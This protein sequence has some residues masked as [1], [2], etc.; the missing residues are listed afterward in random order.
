[1]TT[2]Q[3]NGNGKRSQLSVDPRPKTTGYVSLASQYQ[4]RPRDLPQLSFDMIRSM[5]LDPAVRLGLAMRTAPICGI[6][7]AYKGESG[8]DG[9]PKWIPGVLAKRP[10]VAE[11][12]RRQ[13]ARIWT[14][15]LDDILTAQVWGWSAGEVMN[16]LTSRGTVEVDYLL[17]RHS[18]D[19]RALVRGGEPVGCRVLRV[20]TVPGGHVDLEFPKCW[21]H[22]HHPEAGAFY[23]QSILL[24]AYS[25]WADKAFQGGATDIRRLF[26]H[27]DAYGGKDMTYPDGVTIINGVEV[28]NRDIA[29]QIAEQLQSGGVTA[30]PSST[31]QH[32]NELWKL[33][34]ATVP[35]NPS[36]ILQFP[37]D[38]DTEIYHG[39]EI[40]DD[41]IESETGA[42]A[43]KRVPMAAFYN[44]LDL[45][46]M[47]L[48]GDL[49][50]QILEPLVLINFG[51]AEEFAV[52]HKPLGLQAMEQQSQA[53]PGQDQPGGQPGPAQRPPQLGG[54]PGSQ[55]QQQNGLN[56]QA[57]QQYRMGLEI[58]EAV[59]MG[60]LSAAELV[61]ATRR[62]IR[63]RTRMNVT[64]DEG[65]VHSYSSTQFNLPPELASRVRQMAERIHRDDLADDGV[66]FEPHITVKYG[67]HTNDAD[68]VRRTVSD[69][70]PVAIT[71]GSTSIF[72]SDEHDVVKVDIQSD[73]L[74]E[75]NRWLSDKLPHTD[76]HPGYKPHLTIAYV[77]PGLGDRIAETLNDLMGAVAIFDRLT[78]SDRE[79]KQHSIMLSGNAVRF[80]N[81]TR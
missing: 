37:K 30:R 38:L 42:W 77:K 58:E 7:I 19:V 24:G 6:E 46:A 55:P 15:G 28:A 74:K 80:A 72:Q 9:K 63:M 1:M 43:G 75:L 81:G 18:S 29:M 68:E 61:K 33:T 73:G 27:A 70:P 34:R 41:V 32:G 47:S 45:W 60:V 13:L 69:K 39:L 79:S 14:H 21:W 22:A 44:S 4:M 62:V 16:R 59:G 49:T 67:L 12:V 23:G 5:L 2:Q 51:S 56:G 66:E 50:C 52:T 36:H 3:Q 48:L 64:D 31:D 57:Q 71:F 65:H 25:P 20:P 11:F 8:P 35:S 54:Q 26:M 76:T 10:E 40:P 53:T 78:F 17:G